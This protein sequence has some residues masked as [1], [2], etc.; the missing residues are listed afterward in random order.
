MKRGEREGGGGG[1]RNKRKKNL[2][3][4]VTPLTYSR[5][6]PVRIQARN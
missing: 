6:T 5:D 2:A 3:E 1:S 4:V